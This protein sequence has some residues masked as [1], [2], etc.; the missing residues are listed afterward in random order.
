MDTAIE[1]AGLVKKAELDS[2]MT[3]YLAK[4]QS[5]YKKRDSGFDL[6]AQQVITNM[7]KGWNLGNT[8]DGHHQQTSVDLTKG[9]E[10]ILFS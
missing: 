8:L 3:A 6:T 5:K 9:R 7:G 1:N 4:E 2:E 10:Y